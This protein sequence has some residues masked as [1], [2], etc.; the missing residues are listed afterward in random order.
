MSKQTRLP[1]VALLL[2]LLGLLTLLVWPTLMSAAPLTAFQRLQAAW[3]QANERGQYHYQTTLVQNTHPTAKLENVGR[4]P[5]TQRM[6]IEGQV[7]RPNDLLTLRVQGLSGGEQR[8]IEL[9]VERGVAY[10]RVDGKR[11]WTEVQA[12]AELFAPGGDPLGF[13]VAADNVRELSSSEAGVDPFLYQD[14]LP[15]GYAVGVK[16]YA[17]ELNG[18]RYAEWMRQQMEAQLRQ[19][20]ELPSSLNL[21][22]LSTYV[23]MQGQGEIWVNA[24]GLPVRQLLTLRFP[25]EKGALNWVEA[26]IRGE[27]SNWGQ[28][29]TRG[30]IGLVQHPGSLLRDPRTL[31]DISPQTLEQTGV[32]LSSSFLLLGFVVLTVTYRRDRR[33]YGAFAVAV[34]LM[35]VSGPLLRIQQADAFFE[36]QS[37]KQQEAQARQAAQPRTEATAAGPQG[38]NFNPRVAPLPELTQTSPARLVPKLGVQ[39]TCSLTN[40]EADCDSDGLTNGAEIYKLGTSPSEIDSDDDDISDYQEVKGANGWYLD[41][42]NPDSNGDGALDGL[43]CPQLADAIHDT[44][45]AGYPKGN[46][47]NSDSDATPNV[48]DFDDDGDGVPDTVDIAPYSVLGSTT[49]GLTN[50]TLNFS[51]TVAG[52]NKP[53]FV[54][55]D[56]RPTD[57][58]HFWYTNNVYDWR[59]SDTQGQIKRVNDETFATYDPA[60]YGDSSVMANG[61]MQLMPML[62]IKVGYNAANPSAGLPI[63]PT[64]TTAD[65]TNYSDLSWLDTAA[66]AELGITASAS[67]DGTSMTLWVPL[68]LV[69]DAV[70]DMPVAW[71][72][73]MLY[74]PAAGVTSLGNA[75]QVRLVWLVQAL[76]DSCDTSTL[77]KSQDYD[78]H[79]A[80]DSGNWKTSTAVVQSYYDSF[81]LTGLTVREDHGGQVA[82]IAQP[83]GVGSSAYEDRLWHLASN[84]EETLMEA[85]SSGGNRFDVTDIT[86]TTLSTWGLGGLSVTQVTLADQTDLME[87]ASGE[88]TTILNTVFPTATTAVSTT[89]T[90]LFAGE[91]TARTLTLGD[92]AEQINGNALT[93]DLTDATRATLDTTAVLRWAPYIYEG[94]GVW[95]G[96]SLT[97]YY[98]QLASSLGPVFTTAHLSTIAGGATL[99]DLSKARA[100]AV[101]LAQNYYVSLSAGLSTPVAINGTSLGTSSVNNAVLTLQNGQEPAALI[102]KDM[103]DAI[104]DYYADISIVEALTSESDTATTSSLSALFAGSLPAVL[105]ALGTVALGTAS[106]TLSLAVQALGNYYKTAHVSTSKF[107]L[108]ASITSLAAASVVTSYNTA[109]S[110][111]YTAVK[112]V[113]AVRSLQWGLAVYKGANIAAIQAA[114]AAYAN[115]SSN[116][117]VTKFKIL[118]T[119]VK[120]WAVITFVV[121]TAIVWTLYA[122]GKYD[123]DLERSA[124]RA[125]TIAAT[126]VAAI[127]LVIGLI[128][129]VGQ[130]II[131][132]IAIIDTLM[133][134][135]CKIVGVESGSDVDVWVCSGVTG[136][137]TRVIMYL[138]FDQV[139]VVNLAKEDRLKIALDNP[140]LNQLTSTS[141]FVVGNSLT[142]KATITNT[143]SANEPTGIGSA[144]ENIKGHL[145]N[146]VFGYS[147]QTSK[148]DHHDQLPAKGSQ[149]WPSN[150]TRVFTATGTLPFSGA[151]VNRRHA[152]YLT[153]SFQMD[154]LECWGFI[155]QDCDWKNYAD[156]LHSDIGDN[157]IFDVFPI[158]LSGFMSLAETSEGN[159][160]LAWDGNFPT[161]V[162]ADGDG[163]RS[164]ATGG[165]D[166]DDGTAD[167]DGDGLSDFWEMKNGFDPQDPDDDADGLQDYWE[168]FSGTNPYL[169]DSDHDG[170]SDN[171]EFFHSGNATPYGADN[172]A[173]SG[174]WLVTYGY[175]A[176]NQA[177][178]TRV[179]A[180]PLDYDTDDDS[181]QD[182]REYLYGYNPNVPSVVNILT[183]NTEIAARYTTSDTKAVNI[184]APGDTIPYTATIANEL[185]NRAFSGL[186]QAEL[187]VDS[188]QQTQII[189]TLLPQQDVTMSGSV[190]APVIGAT[191]S[192][193]LTLRAGVVIDMAAANRRLWLKLDEAANTTSFAD[194]SLREHAFSCTAGSCPTANSSYLYFNGSQQIS[195]AHH[196]DFDL[197][198]FTV[199]M[200]IK[201][202]SGGTGTDELVYDVNDFGIFLVNGTQLSVTTDDVQRLTGSISTSDW[203]DVH[204]TYDQSTQ[205][206]KLYLN[207]S[208]LSSASNVPAISRTASSLRSGS[209]YA[210]TL[211]DLVVWSYALSAQEIADQSSGLTF[212][213]SFDESGCGNYKD[214]INNIALNCV[215][216]GDSSPAASANGAVRKSVLFADNIFDKDDQ[217]RAGSSSIPFAGS[218]GAFSIAFWLGHPVYA[219]CPARHMLFTADPEEQGPTIWLEI[220]PQ[221]GDNGFDLKI[222]AGYDFNNTASAITV[223]DVLT[224]NTWAHF[225]ITYDGVSTMIVYKNGVKIGT[226][227]QTFSGPHIASLQYLALGR[228]GIQGAGYPWTG[229]LDELRLY[230]K[231]LVEDDVASLYTESATGLK[232]AF[233]EPPGQTSFAD[234]SAGRYDATCAGNTCPESGLPGRDNQALRFT[235]SNNERLTLPADTEDL[236]LKKAS[237]TVMAWV[238]GDSFGSGTQTILGTNQAPNLQYLQMAVKD[239]RPYMSFGSGSDLQGNTTLENNRWYHLAWVYEY[240]GQTSADTLVQQQRLYVNGVLDSSSSTRVPFDWNSAVYIGQ[241]LGGNFYDG[242]LDHLVISKNPLSEAEIQAAMKEAPLLNLHLDED[243]N[244]GSFANDSPFSTNAQCDDCPTPGAKGQM[245]EAPIFKGTALLTVPGSDDLGLTSFSVGLWVKPDGT[246]NQ[247][248]WLLRRASDAGDNMNYGLHLVAN[249][250]KVAFGYNVSSGPQSFYEITSN[251]SLVANQWNHVLVTYDAASRTASI[252]LNGSLDRAVVQSG[253]GEPITNYNHI[254]LGANFRGSLDEVTVYGTSLASYEVEAVYDYQSAWYDTTVSHRITV[255]ADNPSVA[256]NVTDGLF[257]T[258]EPI[259][260]GISATDPSSQRVKQVAVTVTPPNA[261][262]YTEQATADGNTWV[263]LFVPSGAGGYSIQVAATD[264][265][266]NQA[267]DSKTI[268]VDADAPFATLNEAGAQIKVSESVTL[269]GGVSDW[270]GPVSS[271][272]PTNTVAVELLD[273]QGGLVSGYQV[274]TSDG[275]SWQAEYPLGPNPYGVYSVT[276]ALADQAGNAVTDTVGMVSLDSLAPTGDVALATGLLTTSQTLVGTVSDVPYPLASKLFHLHL[277]EQNGAT[278]FSDSYRTHLSATCSGASCPTAGVSGQYSN[279][280]LFDGN[281]EL[282]L[283][284]DGGLDAASFTLSLWIKPTQQGTAQTLV[285]KANA[286]GSQTQFALGIPANSL[287]TQFTLIG[288]NCALMENLT[289]SGPLTAD[290]WNHVAVSFDGET[291]RLSLNGVEDSTLETANGLCRDDS[292][293]VTLGTGLVGGL[294]EVAFFNTALDRTII[295]DLTNPLPVG[296]ASAELRFRHGQDANQGPDA[297]TW[298]TLPLSSNTDP[299]AT[300]QQALPA[301]LE[302]PYKLDLKTSDAL[303]NSGVVTDVWSGD[304]DLLAPRLS[305]D[306]DLITPNYARVQCRA[307]DYNLTDTNWVC[308]ASGLTSVSEDAAWFTDLF[309]A[310]SKTV[311]LS[312][313]LQLVPVSAGSTMTA[314]DSVGHCATET[315]T[316]TLLAEA[317]A[318]LSPDD[319]SVYVW[320]TTAAPITITGIARSPDGLGTLTVKANGV[321]IYTKSWTGSETE[322]S[323]STSWQPPRWGSYNL[324]AT[325]TTDTNRTISDPVARQ[326]TVRAAELTLSKRVTPA[327]GLTVGQALTYTLVLTNSGNLTATDVL[328]TDVLPAGVSGNNLNATVTLAPNTST[329]FTIP[330]TYVTQVAPT[331]TNTA[332]FTDNWQTGTISTPFTVCDVF[333]VSNANDSGPG[334]LRQALTDA[335]GTAWIRF[336]G[337]FTIYLNSTLDINKSLTVDGGDHEITLSGDSSNDGDRD[338]RVLSIAAGKTVTI[339]QVDVVS[340][341]IARTPFDPNANGGGISNLGTLILSQSLLADNVSGGGGGYSRGGAIY[342][343]G[344]LTVTESTFLSNSTQ[345]TNLFSSGG[346][347]YNEGTLFLVNSTFSGNVATSSSG[348]GGGAVFNIA[349]YSGVGRATLVYN[350]FVGNS[351][352]EGGAVNNHSSATMWL[353]NNIIEQN[354]TVAPA[355]SGCYG[356][357][358]I[359][360][361]HNIIDTGTFGQ[362]SGCNN[363]LVAKS[364]NL[365][366]L[367]DYGGPTPIFPL[368]LGTRALDAGDPASCPAIDGRGQPRPAGAACDIGA[369]EASELYNCYTFNVTSAADSGDGTLRQALAAACENA[370]ISFA[371]DMTIT[372][373]STLPV[374]RTVTVDGSGHAVSLSGGGSVRPLTIGA[375][376][377]VTLT[378]LSLIN[379]LASQGGAIYNQGALTLVQSTLSGNQATTDG[380][381]LYNLGALALVQSTLSGNQA[382]A[383]GGAI[384]NQGTLTL[385]TLTVSGNS[386]ARGGAIANSGSLTLTNSSLLSNTATSG[387]GG[388]YQT[389]GSLNVGNST[390]S[391]NSA[392]TGGGGIE[393]AGGSVT[394]TNATI[395]NNSGT[396]AG[397][398]VSGAGATVNLSKTLLGDNGGSYDCVNAGTLGT[399]SNNLIERKD[400]SNSCGTPAVNADPLLAVLGNYGGATATH[401]LL[402][403]SPAIDG[404]S[405]CGTFDQRG[406]GRVESCDIGAFESQSFTLTITGGNNQSTFINTTFAQPLALTVTPNNPVE[407]VV[408][409]VIWFQSSLATLARLTPT[410]F[411]APIGTG[412][413]VS[414][415]AT[416]NSTPGTYPVGASVPG[417]DVGVTYTLTNLASNLGISKSTSSPYAL[418]GE[419][420]TYT[421]SFSNSGNGTASNTVITDVFPA[422]LENPNYTASLPTTLVGTTNYVWSLG[423]LAP[424]AS[425]TITVSGRVPTSA[426]FGTNYANTATIGSASPE[427][428]TSNN[429]AS[430][431]PGPKVCSTATR[432]YVDAAATGSNTGGSWAN[433]FTDLQDALTLAANCGFASEVWVAN[434]IYYPDEGRGQTDGNTSAAFTLPAGLKVYGG[435]AGGESSLSERDWE[436]NLTI[437][438]GDISQDDTT[439]ANGV[440][441]STANHVGNN[442]LHVV[443]APSATNAT[444]LDGFTITAGHASGSSGHADGG[445]MSQPGRAVLA[446]LQFVGNYAADAGGGLNSY[447]GGPTLEDLT[448]TRNSATV[449]GGLQVEQSQVTANGL[450]VAGNTASGGA[451]IHVLDFGIG[452]RATLTLSNARISGNKSADAAVAVSGGT[453]TMTNV[454]LSGNQNGL[455]GDAGS[456]VSVQ[457]GLRSGRAVVTNAIVWGNSWPTNE[458]HA[459]SPSAVIVRDSIVAGGCPSG[460]GTS[461]VSCTNIQNVD[462]LLA[463]APSASAAP[464]TSGDLRLL[465]GSPAID[466]GAASGAPADDIR[467]ISRPQG[468]GVDI[469][470][471]EAQGWTL[472]LSGG[473]NQTGALGSPFPLPLAATLTSIGNDAVGPGVVITFTAPS[474]GPSLEPTVV[475]ATTNVS[476]TVLATV[477]ANTTAG[478]YLVTATTNGVANSIEYHLTNAALPD[479]VLSKSVDPASAT[480]GQA[481]TYLLT[482]SNSGQASAS[483]VVLTDVM[484]SEVTVNDIQTQGDAGVTITPA[485]TDPYVW[486]ISD[487]APGQGG[488][489]TINAEVRADSTAQVITNTATIASNEP[490]GTPSNNSA[491]AVATGCPFTQTVTNAADSGPGSLR[492]ALADVCQGSTITFASDLTIYLESSLELYKGVTIDGAGHTVIISGD[493]GTRGDASD[494]VVVLVVWEAASPMNLSNLTIR[495][496]YGAE[497]PGGVVMGPGV[498]STIWGSSILANTSDTYQTGGILNQGNM[499]IR[500]STIAGNSSK[501]AGGV[502]NGYEAQMTIIN[503]TISGNASLSDGGGGVKNQYG[504]LTISHSTIASNTSQLV[505]IEGTISGYGAG[506]LNYGGDFAVQQ[507]I[508]AGN[509]IIATD[510]QTSQA[511]DCEGSITDGG[512]NLIGDGS[513][514]SEPTSQSGDPLLAPLGNYGGATQTHALLPGSPALDAGDSATCEATD[515]RG[516]ARPVGV[517]C[518]I[519]AFES[520]GFT[521]AITSGNNQSTT[522]STTFAAP[523]A[524]QVAA[525]STGEPIAGGRL[526]F[527][528]P[529]AGASL[530]SDTISATIPANGAVS[531]A[532]SANDTAGSY[533]VTANTPGA[534]APV[535]FSL[536]NLASN[537]TTT[538]AD[539]AQLCGGSQPCYPSWQQAIN[540]VAANGTV[541]VYPGSYSESVTLNSNVSVVL[542]GDVTLNGDLTLAA[543]TLDVSASNYGL[544]VT[545]NWI[546]SGGSFTPRTGTVT[547]AGS[548]QTLSGSTS[549]YGLSKTG[550]TTDTLTF[551]AG[552]TQTVQGP[553]SL[554]GAWNGPLALRSSTTGSRW[555]INAQGSRILRALDVKDSNNLNATAMSALISSDSGNNVNWLFPFEL[556]QEDSTQ[557]DYDS[558]QSVADASASS[559]SYRTSSVSGQTL[560]FRAPSAST[561]LTFSTYRG[562][563]QGRARLSIDG[564]KVVTSIDLYAPAAMAGWTSYTFTAPASTT[565]TTLVVSVQ[566]LKNAASTNTLVR[567]DGLGYASQT[568]NENSFRV[569]YNGWSLSNDVAA[570]SGGWQSFSSSSTSRVSFR[571]S[572]TQ[573]RWLGSRGPNYGQ[574]DV[575]LDG[576]FIRTVDQYNATKKAQVTELFNHI[577]GVPLS[578]DPHTLEIR[579]KG[580]R[581]GASTGNLVSVDAFRVP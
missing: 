366:A 148:Q 378:S 486:T 321:T 257:V 436:T 298:Y 192:T 82:V 318:I 333:D 100:G 437:L 309:G 166:P 201:P 325:L 11:E 335:C 532:V 205:Q 178:E 113:L 286:G 214:S 196:S 272:I 125:R 79:C 68:T 354:T 399:N 576:I 50:D 59:D 156:S 13:L 540:L 234:Q 114:V 307:D 4:R 575:Y 256:L 64:K 564:S 414:V 210:G 338:V 328:V 370:T 476:G 423:N 489:I 530:S 240:K 565:Y 137:V 555:N 269:T 496:G 340:G 538:Y 544:T 281:D 381:A 526:R 154:A 81:Y 464:T 495:D 12:G 290:A 108:T 492:Q 387:G 15:Q 454:T 474:S 170:L 357:G 516:I 463:D 517:A 395:A 141:G 431:S 379:G 246:L 453:L 297:G 373:A 66:L 341:T 34:V 74:R 369:Y 385:N 324:T 147:L 361:S 161:Q 2:A 346:G 560:S 190:G 19:K 206:L 539:P 557:V 212:Y 83:K 514:L 131:A 398:L 124:A 270:N 52:A 352:Y 480:P 284:A 44:L 278:S 85:Q 513:C 260:L 456:L 5:I 7:N 36:Q 468:S 424:N 438:S 416:A 261:A 331:I 293:R 222:K 51:M 121:T 490:D 35:M 401:A 86:T 295:Y 119:D 220:C 553:L 317:V 29:Q 283:A 465:P 129:V 467:G 202:D 574:A 374:T 53:V 110:S 442:S 547:L 271:G 96:Y 77:S 473:D 337:D 390:L 39:A 168:A 27:F 247:D 277:E 392:T 162:D 274:A 412:G 432:L 239:G 75:Q 40:T 509:H 17:F 391:G 505:D 443:I 396:T 299:A 133:I 164:K 428:T 253:T 1:C 245:R 326:I 140:T 181:V 171:A 102:V 72:A 504:T 6:V 60:S 207:G 194:A 296:I 400:A 452:A 285:R 320:D 323:W 567:I 421:I 542:A 21:G 177:L 581:N 447:Q 388:L 252:Y 577:G 314:C 300:W 550:T 25:E 88:T 350:T 193:S 280:A 224:W 223:P 288:E 101:A 70:G 243:L 120:V 552:S 368:L 14:L 512:F 62:E 549:F 255:D 287:N 498:T 433:A 195:L 515:Q 487:L 80:A 408:G 535:G 258:N 417:L 45:A 358:T 109:L 225:V 211:D 103:V 407:P 262:P 57:P 215:T 383:D 132:I 386:A 267:F 362:T 105:E 42:L 221:F 310:L 94:A 189:E 250:L 546:R 173:W 393:A 167:T 413:T 573:A 265:V 217:I 523:L 405:G 359:T 304:I 508:V 367:G 305:F 382:T 179:S 155:I 180:D 422:A 92:G 276:M 268:Y 569:K 32:A 537:N 488:T 184:V 191:E 208:L 18:V 330:A 26:E 329:S 419:R 47:R 501:G 353:S 461:G 130:I 389:A 355:G 218:D 127:Y 518:D 33:L 199:S 551:Q 303:G 216:A 123:N 254:R 435:F 229:R 163:L 332:T 104:Q 441:Q 115:G 451:A 470:A 536:T 182:D 485:G 497:N 534:S 570:S 99:S 402:P 494:N 446:N 313:T 306:Y 41:P 493:A 322:A 302:G 151:G 500:N 186:L 349:A 472:T 457:A 188:V 571:F 376:G 128:P 38:A 48:F 117:V 403:G 371:S 87:V 556:Y 449:G 209:G 232:L 482:F 249:S 444:R 347:I 429:Q 198:S 153:E 427:T 511:D 481:L 510:G 63:T 263:Y 111:T 312:T 364:A 204:V 31:V 244:T 160:R 541:V 334:S 241:S 415:T 197:G 448:F 301:G 183:L 112:G 152:F 327:A 308:P 336:T 264:F 76:V 506:I 380:G 144:A 136:I 93:L 545:G 561:S 426:T 165:S 187:P 16:R 146:S 351:A 91:A 230:R 462:P 279:A 471:Y 491:V 418:Q 169:S 235:A 228:A 139:T 543:G 292:Q 572:G 122:L 118:M 502:S 58:D 37:A 150:Y 231:A 363:G 343:S 237:F 568:V 266:G 450:T 477:T 339:T 106:N 289:S 242:L 107:T 54:E 528:A 9:K 356:E 411:S 563:D 23:K 176:S 445:G 507:S 566:G 479:L 172:S 43:E 282:T 3:G 157:L 459:N 311:T 527:S 291:V 533:S 10:G 275:G 73:T 55:F 559:G 159:Y 56:L 460:S 175:N 469:G 78:K 548:N 580:T 404:A 554:Q 134:A 558:W 90:L 251:S 238:K 475:T 578:D 425:G 259:E 213:A 478:S 524:V 174:G 24:E 503:S 531:V 409:G 294:D 406:L 200:R 521:L 315:V 233:D 458:F 149:S 316:P 434:G 227:T 439:D 28:A 236:G 522:V 126:I 420:I 158:T 273:A 116:L 22:L 499:T 20:G 46:C 67:E 455:A 219:A 61:D 97:S 185:D 344:T 562:P 71:S 142:L 89:T 525:N 248:Q 95:D 483:G 319:G 394:L 65:I 135:I 372:L 345:G 365:G 529:T 84:L 143:I 342:N 226:Y 49:T 484:P 138:I 145:G 348:W 98:D 377:H 8:A 30:L 520:Q 384:A 360:A 375:T 410:L 440:V 69:Q 203:S 466:S 397:G 579:V 519:G 430:V